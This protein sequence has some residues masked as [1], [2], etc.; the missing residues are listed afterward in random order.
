MIEAASK[1]SSL[2]TDCNDLLSENDYDLYNEKT[3]INKNEAA[4][5]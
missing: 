5:N 2:F 3:K 1:R 4:K